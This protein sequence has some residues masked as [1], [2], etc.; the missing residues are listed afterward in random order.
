MPASEGEAT[1]VPPNTSHPDS[2]WQR[3]L[4]Y[5]ETPVL[6]LAS[7]EKS[8][9]PRIPFRLMLGEFLGVMFSTWYEG[10]D[11]YWLGPPPLPLQVVSLLKRCWLLRLTDVPPAQT[12]G[13]GLR[14]I[15]VVLDC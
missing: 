12:S 8:G 15:Q 9:A 10:S 4:S 7:K 13:L 5:T 14:A 6:G 11:S 1:L 3:V 2:P